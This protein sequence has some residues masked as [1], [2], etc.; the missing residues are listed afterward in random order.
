M[1]HRLRCQRGSVLVLVAAAMFPIIGM[2]TFAIDVSHW[3]DYSRNLQNRA[4]AA[5]FAGGQMLGSCIG[6]TGT[7]GNTTNGLQSTAGKWAQLYTGAS[8]GENAANVPYTDAQ[9]TAAT[10]GAAGSGNGPGTGWNVTQN[11]YINNTRPASPVTSPL[12]LVAGLANINNFWVALNG[13]NYA[14]STRGNTS[15]KMNSAGSGATFCNSDPT[16]DATDKECFG[17]PEPLP[18][19]SQLAADCASGAMVDVKLTQQRIPLFIPLFSGLNPTI[20]AHARV[21]LHGEA[22]AGDT[23]AIA[24][25]DPGSFACVTVYFKNDATNAILGTAV[26]TETD[27]A[28][29]VFSNP[30]AVTGVTNSGPTSVTIPTGA[31]VY[32]QPFLSDC[33]GNGE[34]FDDSTNTGI[35]L[36]NSFGTTAPTAGQAPKIT[37]GGVTLAVPSGGSCPAG[38]DQYF[39]SGGCN[40]QPTAHVTFAVPKSDASVTAVDLGTSPATP[41]SL[42]PD[43]TG[44]IWTPNGQQHFTI[45]DQTGQHPIRIDWSQTSGTVAGVTCGT[46]NGQSPPPCKGTFGIQQQTFGACNGCD[47]PDDSGPIAISQLRLSTDAAGVTGENAFQQGTTE[48]F[49]VTLELAGIRAETNANAKPTIIRFSGS[50]NHQTGLVDCGQGN[51]GSNDAYV[52][53]GGCGPNNPFEPP[54]C[55]TNGLSCKLPALNPLYIYG[56]GNP[57]DC[58]PAQDQNYTGWPGGNHQDCVQ[59]TPGTRR[60]D[61]VCGLIQWVTGVS[62]AAFNAS[63]SA[64][65]GSTGGSCTP[66]NWPDYNKDPNDRRKITFILTS[67]LDLAAA[68]GAPQFW[69]PI[70]RFATFYVTGWDTGLNPNCGNSGP[71]NND[72]FPGAAGGKAVSNG[73]IWG[74][75]IFDVDNGGVPSNGGCDLNSIEPINCVPVLTR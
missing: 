50:N 26:L 73:A 66:N 43:S 27:P 75:W 58:S 72:K 9:I 32:A 41:L 63:S 13:D 14:D 35:E 15:F 37:A 44:K 49:V 53:Y 7:P 18:A 22:S 60:T 6:T 24:V 11:G 61:I 29:F 67:P 23:R 68:A 4:D 51:G 56:R 45:G 52:I 30:V 25:S 36:I 5:A 34:T 70:R 12:T 48:Q 21:T 46:G 65:Q 28:N 54:G 74:H 71:P 16:F 47:Q 40:V 10:N 57:T 31:N 55:T 62:A 17:Q 1:S 8:V 69:I 33:S 3:F 59:T 39:S 19:G 38:T 20:H 42:S 64:C 2:L